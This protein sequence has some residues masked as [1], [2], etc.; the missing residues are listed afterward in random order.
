LVCFAVNQYFPQDCWVFA[1][2]FFRKVE[3]FAHHTRQFLPDAEF[4][5]GCKN[6]GGNPRRDAFT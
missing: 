4:F 6:A 2:G 1:S 5:A 3:V